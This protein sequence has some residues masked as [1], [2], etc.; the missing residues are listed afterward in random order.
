MLRHLK[1]CKGDYKR[2]RNFASATKPNKSDSVVEKKEPEE[3]KFK[4]K[5]EPWM[6]HK[7]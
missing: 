2:K 6:K 4:F 5:V 1:T 7:I 3:N